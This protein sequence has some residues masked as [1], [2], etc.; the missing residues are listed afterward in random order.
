[1]DANEWTYEKDVKTECWTH[2]CGKAIN[3]ETM[4]LLWCDEA[5]YCPFC[6]KKCTYNYPTKWENEVEE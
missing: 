4:R 3:D 5:K 6:G 1:M 2:D